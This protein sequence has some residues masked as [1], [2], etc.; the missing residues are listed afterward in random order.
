[1]IFLVLQ[2]I[3]K[4]KACIYI[5]MIYKRES[6]LVNIK[7][8]NTTQASS[9]ATMLWCGFNIH[10][11]LI[12]DLTHYSDIIMS[13]MTSQITSLTIVYSTVYS[14]AENIKALH[15]WPLWGEFTGDQ[16]IPR[17]KASNTENVSIWW[18]HH[19]MMVTCHEIY[20]SLFHK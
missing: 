3:H 7:V 18:S 10:T 4:A 14:R 17:T 6:I 8:T 15:H 19:A 9:T 12:M 11:P 2:M 20:F 5:Y 16:W 13:T 1:M